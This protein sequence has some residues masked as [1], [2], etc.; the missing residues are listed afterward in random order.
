MIPT[1]FNP[2]ATNFGSLGYGALMGTLSCTVT[3]QLG[4]TGVYDLTLSI[5][6]DDPLVKFM[7][8]GWII[9]AKP[10]LTDLNQAFV[11]ESMSKPINNII[12]VYATHIAQHRAKLIPVAPINATDLQDALS[13]I[14]SN[15]L[16]TNPF[17][18]TSAR[19]SNVDYKTNTPRS[20]RSI[21]GGEEG[22]LLDVYGGE[23]IFD[24]FNIELVSK[25]GRNN[26]VQIVYGQ[27]MTSFNMDEEFSYD[28]SVTGIL[29]YWYSEDEGLVQGSIQYSDYVNYYKYHKTVVRDYTEEFENKPT[30]ND[31]NTKAAA[32]V[33]K[34]GLPFVNLK[35]AFNQF[36]EHV[37]GNVQ[38]MQLGDTVTVI[39]PNYD[40]NTTSRIV[41]MT[42]NV[43]SEQYDEIQIGTIVETIN[44]AIEN[45]VKEPKKMNSN[46][47]TLN[48]LWTNSN[49]TSSFAAQNVQ[50]DPTG[51]KYLIIDC[52]LVTNNTR[53]IN[54]VWIPDGRGGVITSIR[55]GQASA[56]DRNFTYSNGEIQ[57]SGC[58]KYDWTTDSTSTANDNLIPYKIL[59]VK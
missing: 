58:T 5:D 9:S 23:Y 48:V 14:A 43:L 7:D 31:L 57:F 12:S 29:P 46:G 4:S 18:L 8:I 47:S 30:A 32:D 10:N 45:T 41:S 52:Y 11:I 59:G 54:F 27:S 26:G 35:I 17:S 13:K 24:N 21:L 6:A 34:L 2:Y 44:Q 53:Q 40:I 20:F 28:T 1:L 55:Y 49:P 15:S 42:F 37:Q 16:E 3:E 36:E 39:N 19:T 51:Y 25:R 38:I 50:V 56:Y 22:S 33:Q